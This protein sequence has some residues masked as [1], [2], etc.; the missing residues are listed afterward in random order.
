MKQ[1]ASLM[2]YSYSTNKHPG[3]VSRLAIGTLLLTSLVAC[4]S[5]TSDPVESETV[6]EQEPAMGL[7]SVSGM[8]S[9]RDYAGSMAGFDNIIAS[10]DSDANSRRLA[11]LGKALIYLGSDKNW[12]SI[13]NA[14]MS[15]NAAGSVVPEGGAEFAIETDMLM[16]S[17][18]AQIGSESEYQVLKAKTGN[19]KAEITRLQNERDALAQE[20]D[21]LLKEQQALNEALEKL[22]NLT[23][24]S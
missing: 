2:G 20:R 22:K 11:H 6:A 4:A 14:N 9:T 1:S 24:G 5:V 10:A 17:I 3:H 13:D 21:E 15:L 18:A 7:A 8:Y 16:D 23:L 12:H 19:S